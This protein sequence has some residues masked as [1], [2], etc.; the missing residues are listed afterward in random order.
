MT[1]LGIRSPL[2]LLA[3][4]VLTEED[5]ARYSQNALLNTDDLPY[6][7][8]SAPDS[9]YADTVD[10]NWRVLKSF[11]RR[12]FPPVV[13]LPEGS[14]TSTAFQRDLGLVLW[15]KESSSEALSH[16]DKA[17]QA[18]PGD[19]VAL[20]HRGKI[21]LRSGSVLLAEA[22]F[23]AVLRSEP[24]NV[25]AHEALANLYRGQRMSDL[26]EEH[27]RKIVALRPTEPRHLAGLADLLRDRRRFD[28]AIPQ[29][30]AA[31]AIAPKDA[32]LW[33]GLGLAY[34][35]A[36]RPANALDAFHRAVSNDPENAFSLYQLGLANLEAKRFDEALTALRAASLKDPLRPEVYLALGRLH[37]ARSDKTEALQAFR[38]CLRL[39]PLNTEALK[40]VEELS[41]ALYGS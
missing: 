11:E 6:L 9:L 2:A 36:G 10:L 41:V 19:A 35:G 23:K 8:F 4:F 18:N 1:R 16:F 20:L 12:P 31:V 13:G 37:L 39:E 38:H 40:A 22:D 34:Q 28:E 21:H 33:T 25:E 3:D 24:P 7:E 15:A 32:R 26:A 29:Y 30:V 27:L 5:A 14:L 17:L